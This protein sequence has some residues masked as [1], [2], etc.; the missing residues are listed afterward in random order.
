MTAGWVGLEVSPSNKQP[1][2]PQTSVSRVAAPSHLGT[3]RGA[4]TSNGRQRAHG[5]THALGQACGTLASG[6]WAQGLC[7]HAPTREAAPPS[8]TGAPRGGGPGL[9]VCPSPSLF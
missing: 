5:K 8:S 4:T 1:R 2:S 6:P 9:G 7:T 3:Q